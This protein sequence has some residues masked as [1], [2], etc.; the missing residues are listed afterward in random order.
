MAVNVPIK[1]GTARRLG[2]HPWWPHILPAK[3]VKPLS[4]ED[5]VEFARRF[6]EILKRPGTSWSLKTTTFGQEVVEP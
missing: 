5:A 3:D 6:T 2:L 1:R 4:E